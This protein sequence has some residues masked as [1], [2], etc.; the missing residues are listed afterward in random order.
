MNYRQ[1]CITYDMKTFM[2][3]A[4]TI[5]QDRQRIGDSAG[6]TDVHG[7]DDHLPSGSPNDQIFTEILIKKVSFT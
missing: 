2:K 7:N 3:R 6:I 4:Y 1:R 5:L